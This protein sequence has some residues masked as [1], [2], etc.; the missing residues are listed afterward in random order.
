M[1]NPLDSNSKLEQECAKNEGKE[2]LYFSV[3]ESKHDQT[4]WVADEHSKQVFQ[5]LDILASTL[6]K[7]RYCFLYKPGNYPTMEQIMDC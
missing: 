7:I 5:S 2:V 3:R 4:E 1:M 6:R